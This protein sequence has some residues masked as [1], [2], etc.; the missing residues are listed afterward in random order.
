MLDELAHFLR[1]IFIRT[2]HD[3][4]GRVDDNEPHRHMEPRLDL[5][6]KRDD[7]SRIVIAE[8]VDSIRHHDDW[9]VLAELVIAPSS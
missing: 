6:Q 1:G 5:A 3:A 9:S 4:G 7:G 2:R 8:K